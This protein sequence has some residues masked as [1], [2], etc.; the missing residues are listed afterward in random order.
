MDLKKQYQEKAVPQLMGEL[1]VTNRMAVPKMVKV[2]LNIGLGQAAH[3][4][5]VLDKAADQL[6]VITG[7]KPKVT[8]AKASIANFKIRE[9]DPVGLTVTLRGKRMEDFLVK[10][11]TVTLP[12]VRDFHGVSGGAFDKQG[13]YTLGL[14]EQIVFPEIDYAKIDKIRGLEITMVTNA[15]DAKISRRLLEL[16]GI[17]FTKS[18]FLNPKQNGKNIK[19]C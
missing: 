15:G 5:G 17:P 16:I 8:R 1:G 13:N 2:V 10:L 11:I 19:N 9:G 14:H 12:R 3:D 18:K 4:K 6:T 7:Q